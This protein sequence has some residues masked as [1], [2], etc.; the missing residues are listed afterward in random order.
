MSSEY[1]IFCNDLVVGM[2]W[3][4]RKRSCHAIFPSLEKK[5]TTN[6]PLHP[7]EEMPYTSN[8][9][10]K[11]P[12]R[13]ALYCRLTKPLEAMLNIKSKKRTDPDLHHWNG[14]VVGIIQ[15]KINKPSVIVAV[16]ADGRENNRAFGKIL[17]S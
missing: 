2:S 12:P 8:T 17:V 5:L 10:D 13:Y 16:D 1:E 3:H 7:A 11:K 4:I 9:F 15:D 6:S 14:V